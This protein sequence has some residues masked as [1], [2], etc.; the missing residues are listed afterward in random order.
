MILTTTLHI[1]DTELAINQKF[2]VLTESPMWNN[3]LSEIYFEIIRECRQR[4]QH[5]KQLGWP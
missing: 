2:N 1:V 4:E 3:M 5:C